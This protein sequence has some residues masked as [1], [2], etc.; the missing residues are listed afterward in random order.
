MSTKTLTVFAP[1]KINLYLHVTGKLENGYHTLD[2]LV[3]FADIGDEIEIKPGQGFEFHIQGPFANGFSGLDTSAQPDS[4]NLVAK[5]VWGLARLV[6]KTPAFDITLTK[7]LPLGGGIGGGSADAAAVVWA[8]LQYWNLPKD[9]DGLDAFLLSLGADVPVCFLCR[10]VF[11]RG[12]GDVLD[13]T[14]SIP[15]RPVV[16]VN[17]GKRCETPRVFS[18]YDGDYA[19]NIQTRVSYETAEAF[20]AL[21]Y[22]TENVLTNAAIKT[23]PD[24]QNVLHALNAQDGCSTARMSGSGSTCFG[25][26]QDEQSAIKAASDIASQNP[27]W[28]VQNCWIGRTERY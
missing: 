1:A 8:L 12:V 9:L 26:F 23:V 21:L 2:S 20:A 6:R 24:I 16:L 5:A 25:I 3:S 28:W 11:M 27:D 10:S 22:E 15:E 14:V 19:A 13:D 17:P 18:F 4:T 7:N